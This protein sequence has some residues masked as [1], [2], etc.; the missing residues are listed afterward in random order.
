MNDA[1]SSGIRIEPA[2]TGYVADNIVVPGGVEDAL[3]L[4]MEAL[5]L[6]DK[7]E[8]DRIEARLLGAGISLTDSPLGTVW[9][10]LDA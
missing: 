2:P 3:G 1:S 5:R 8:A 9:R 7:Q 6:G 4:R 10:V